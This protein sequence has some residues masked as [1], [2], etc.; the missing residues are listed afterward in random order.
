MQ[1]FGAQTH[2]F[3]EVTGPQQFERTKKEVSNGHQKDTDPI[4][5][6][7]PPDGLL[8]NAKLRV[9]FWEGGEDNNFSIFRVRQFSEW[10]EPLHWIAFPV[11]N[12]HQ[13]P[14]SLNC[15]PPFH[16]ETPYFSL[17]SASSHPL[18]KNWLWETP[19][20]CSQSECWAS[21]FRTVGDP[22]TL[23]NKSI[24]PPQKSFR[25]VLPPVRLVPFPFLEGPPLSNSQSSPWNS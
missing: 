11:E 16:W 10:P 15:L 8:D 19:R 13:T 23:E 4:F 2:L 17:K 20:K 3:S 5:V 18:P 24:F 12:P 6:N 22:Q 14:H 7:P 1:G 25:I 9:N 21:K